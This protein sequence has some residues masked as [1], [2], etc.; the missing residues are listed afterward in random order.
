MT[1][2]LSMEA[3]RHIRAILK[4]CLVL[5][6]GFIVEVTIMA[7]AVFAALLPTNF[8]TQPN[9]ALWWQAL[10]MVA[11]VL[12]GPIAAL[13]TVLYLANRMEL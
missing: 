2:H 7:G 1:S 13:K 3:R 4:G 5:F 12:G 6:V 8:Q 9:G 10:I 11:G